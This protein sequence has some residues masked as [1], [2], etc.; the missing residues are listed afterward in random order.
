ME[1]VKNQ[2]D[3]LID[4]LVQAI[5]QSGAALKQNVETLVQHKMNNISQ[6]KEEGELFFTVVKSCEQ[7]VQDKLQ[8]GSKEDILLEKN[9]MIEK[10]RAVSLQLTPQ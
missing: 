4:K 2:I 7:Y 9:E 5:H 8:E 3:M 6:K 10:L 1:S